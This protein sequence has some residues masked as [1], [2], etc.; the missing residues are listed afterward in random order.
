VDEV[1]SILI[2]EARIPLVIAGNTDE[3]VANPY[4]IAELVRRLRAG[5]D[6]D[7]DE[8][9]RNVYLTDAGLDRAEKALRCDNLP[10]DALLLSQLYQ[11]LHAQALL[12]RDI[13]YIVR[14][15][16]VEIVDEF[17]GRVVE[18]RTG[19]MASKPLSRPSGL[20]SRPRG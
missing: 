18:D 8:N 7:T 19:P 10:G 3:V 12:N 15:G 11:A 13:D 14:D 5:A 4:E 1:D 9:A 17:T 6:Y 16:K 20:T 2:D